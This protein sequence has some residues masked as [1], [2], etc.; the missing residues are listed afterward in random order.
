MGTG[1]LFVLAGVL[2]VSSSDAGDLDLGT[3][4][5]ANVLYRHGDRTPVL[6][7]KNDPY[8]DE[9]CWPV[10]YGQLTNIGKHQHLLLGRWLRK[11]YSH[12]LSNIYSPY[13]IYVESTDV[14][15]TLMSAEANLAGLYPPTGNQVW[16]MNHWMPIP[17]HTVPG[18]YDYVLH[19][20]KL[21][22]RYNYE[23]EKLLSSP[24]MERINKA[25]ANLYAYLSKNTGNNVD[26]FKIVEHLY[27]V[28]FIEQLYNKTLPQWTKSVFPEKMKP[29]AILSFMIETYN[30]I[31]QRLK[32][33]P[34]LGEMIDHMVKKAQRTLQPD[35][36]LWMYSAH[37]ETI[38][39]MLMTLG[40]FEPHCPPYTSM[41][42]MELRAN[43]KNEFFVT[44][45]YKNTTEE[46]IL[47]TL[48]GCATLCPLNE[49]INL[50]K[51]VVP[52]DWEK[53]CTIPALSAQNDISSSDVIAILTSSTLMLV[54][55]VLVIICFMYW[56]HTREHR[57][58]YFRL[59]YNGYNDAI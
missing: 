44:V 25:N 13:D 50:T 26:S 48:P 15:R 14:D 27:D 55:L 41:I 33:G 40:L 20:T 49:F 46:P 37:D 18:K 43:S 54:L 9:S 1:L 8:R 17:V 39:N 31:L 52:E 2:A 56:R 5:F 38:A 6:P 47:M 58:Y 35:R 36:K 29:L 42:L 51:H 7:Y 22:P 45:S 11:R 10:P 32:S 34:L 28:L 12:L 57:Q 19:A 24:E 3:I 21:C 23:L 16:D 4:V 30:T 53:E 59:A